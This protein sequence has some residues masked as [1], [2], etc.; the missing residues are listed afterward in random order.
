MNLFDRVYGKQAASEYVNIDSLMAP[1]VVEQP[2]VQ[3]AQGLAANGFDNVEDVPVFT[4]DRAK[5]GGMQSVMGITSGSDAAARAQADY[6]VQP[7]TFKNMVLP[8][9]ALAA[10]Q[11]AQGIGG[12]VRQIG[13]VVGSGGMASWGKDF[14]QSGAD[15]EKQIQAENPLDEGTWANS[16]RNAGASMY[17]QLPSMVAAGPLVKAG[18]KG[19]GMATA[20]VPMGAVTG[21]QSYGKYRDR[22][23]GVG[24]ASGGSAVDELIEVGTELLP[25]GRLLTYATSPAKLAVKQLA[26]TMIK[27]GAE[28]YFGETLAALGQGITN[29]YLTNPNLTEEQRAQMVNDYF[30]KVN[31]KTGNAEYFDDFKEA[32]RATTAQLVMTAGLGAGAKRLT[33]SRDSAVPT[34]PAGPAVAPG[35]D[36][37]AG[38]PPAAVAPGQSASVA[39][40]SFQNESYDDTED[41]PAPKG[42]LQT[43]TEQA[44]LAVAAANAGTDN[45]PA[46]TPPSPTP[47]TPE[48][49]PPASVAGGMAPSSPVA[50]VV[51]EPVREVTEADQVDFENAVQWALNLEKRGIAVIPEIEGETERDRAW[52]L[53]T[54]YRKA[55]TPMVAQ[56]GG[57]ENG[58]TNSVPEVQST[59]NVDGNGVP[60]PEVQAPVPGSDISQ[61]G[62]Q[63]NGSVQPVSQ[64]GSEG[65]SQVPDVRKEDVAYLLPQ[66]SKELRQVLIDAGYVKPSGDVSTAGIS[67]VKRL[68]KE[69][70]LRDW[71][72]TRDVAD[73]NALIDVVRRHVAPASPADFTPLD[74]NAHNAATSPHN[75]TPEPTL[76]QIE[77]GNYKKGHVTLHGLDISIENPAGSTRKGVDENGKAWET[78]LQHHYGYIKGTIGRDKDHVDVFIKPGIDQTTAGDKIFVIDQKSP[79]TDSGRGSFDEHKVMIGFDSHEEASKAYQSNYDKS[80][81]SRI[82]AVS[83]PSVATFK[84]WLKNGDTT[85]MF[86]GTPWAV[87]HE[88]RAPENKQVT[89]PDKQ[90]WEMT[91]KDFVSTH[92]EDFSPGMAARVHQER[93][94]NAIYDGIIPPESVVEKSYWLPTP[95]NVMGLL[96]KADE[97][98]PGVLKF[99]EPGGAYLGKKGL[100]VFHAKSDQATGLSITGREK[101]AELQ[102]TQEALPAPTN[103]EQEKKADNAAKFAQ[104]RL[105]ALEK[106]LADAKTPADKKKARASLDAHKAAMAPVVVPEAPAAFKGAVFSATPV[107][108]IAG[109]PTYKVHVNPSRLQTLKEIRQAV[110]DGYAGQR[111]GIYNTNEPGSTQLAWGSSFPDY[112]KNKGYKKEEVLRSIDRIIAGKA[113]TE[114]QLLALDDMAGEQ[115]RNAVNIILTTRAMSAQDFN[116]EESEAYESTMQDD[117]TGTPDDPF[118]TEEELKAYWEARNGTVTEEYRAVEQVDSGITKQGAEGSSSNESAGPDSGPGTKTEAGNDSGASPKVVDGFQLTAEK[119]APPAKPKE[120]QDTLFATP[121]QFGSKPTPDTKNDVT[122]SQLSDN[123]TSVESVQPSLADAPTEVSP[124]L[125]Q[126]TDIKALLGTLENRSDA[127]TIERLFSKDVYDMLKPYDSNLAYHL[128]KKSEDGIPAVLHINSGA[129]S[130][131]DVIYQAQA[132]ELMDALDRAIALI[133]KKDAENVRLEEANKPGKVVTPQER[134]DK[135]KGWDAQRVTPATSDEVVPELLG[136]KIGGARKDLETS[137]G[138]GKTKRVKSDVPAWR[139]R[140]MAMEGV[141]DGLWYL[142]DTTTDRKL[143]RRSFP[144]LKEAEEM[145]PLAVVAIKHRVRY[146]SDGTYKI[147]RDV[148]DH[149]RV[150]L[151][152]GFASE[153]EAKKYM[154]TH[155]VE[156]I[157]QDTYFGAEIL[158]RPEKVVRSGAERRSGNAKAQDFMDVFGFRSAEFGNWNN[159]AERQEILNHAYDGLLD[160]ADV[161]GLPTKALSLN[162]DLA[163]A[164]GARGQ[165]LQGAAAHYETDYA[166]INLTKLSGA[167]NLAHEW[168]H[169]VDN[170]FARQDGQISSE[171]VKNKRGDLVYGGNKGSKGMVTTGFLAKNSG[172]REAVRDAFLNLMETIWYKSEQYIE[173]TVKAEKFVGKALQD[174]TDKL[175]SLRNALAKERQYGAKKKAATPEQ[176][177]RFDELAARLVSGKD[178]VIEWRTGLGAKP[179]AGINDR[180]AWG[181]NRWTNDT[182]EAIAALNK[183]ITGRTGFIKEGHGDMNYLASHMRDFERRNKM[184]EEARNSDVKTKKIPTE[185]RQDAYKIDQGRTGDYWTLKEEMAARAFSAYIEDRIAEQGNRSDFLSYGSDNKFYRMFGI[186]P[187]PEGAERK[188]INQAFDDLFAT[189]ETKETDK[190]IAVFEKGEIYGTLD[191][192]EVSYEITSVHNEG[193]GSGRATSNGS[194]S[195]GL[196]RD[197]DSAG[198]IREQLGLFTPATAAASESPTVTP[199]APQFAGKVVRV[200]SGVLRSPLTKIKTIKD[201][202]RVAQP[203]ANRAQEGLIAIV[204]DKSGKILGVVQHTTG[205][206]NQ[207]IVHPR[208]LSGVILDFPGATAVYLAHNHPTG[209]PTPSPEDYAITKRV[210]RVLQAA[211]IEVKASVQVGFTGEYQSFSPLYGTDRETGSNDPAEERGKKLSI[212][213]RNIESIAMAEPRMTSALDFKDARERYFPGQTGILLIDGKNRSVGFIPMPVWQMLRLSTGSKE[214]GAGRIMHRMHETGAVGLMLS[215]DSV[216]NDLEAVRNVISFGNVLGVKVLD[217]TPLTG[218]SMQERGMLPS[219]GDVF[220]STQEFDAPKLVKSLNGNIK[221]SMDKLIQL[222]QA[223]IRDGAATYQQ[224]VAGMKKYL[225]DKWDTFRAAMILVYQQAKKIVAD[226]R[227]MVGIDI[228][229]SEAQQQYNTVAAKYKNSPEWMK[230][231]NGKPTNLNEQQWVQVRTPLFKVWFGDWEKA[232]NGKDG[233]GVWGTDIDVSKVVDENGEPAVVYHGTESGG[234]TVFR[235]DKADRHRSSMIFAA[236]RRDVAQTYSGLGQEVDLYTQEVAAW[237]NDEGGANEETPYYELTPAERRDADERYQDEVGDYDAQR[238]IYSVFLNIRN[239]NEASFEGANWDGTREGQYAVYDE[240]GEQQYTSDGTAFFDNESDAQN[241]AD[242]LGDG[243]TAEPAQ[244]LHET[245]NSIAEEAKKMGNDG[246]IIRDVIDDGG[247]AGY[248]LDPADVFVFF[249]ESQI[250]S[251]VSNTGEFSPGN[252]DIRYS[253]INAVASGVSAAD[254][255]AIV[256]KANAL[257][258]AQLS[259]EQSSKSLPDFVLADMKRRGVKYPEAVTYTK[260]GVSHIVYIADNI[261]GVKRMQA[262]MRHEWFHAGVVNKELDALHKYYSQKIPDRLAEIAAQ[263]KFDLK[264]AEGRR[265]AAGEL[266]AQEA[267]KGKINLFVRQMLAKVKAWLRSVGLASE[268]GDAEVANIIRQAIGR[269]TEQAGNGGYLLN[270]VGNYSLANG[271]SFD[272]MKQNNK[273]GD[274]IDTTNSQRILPGT[275]ETGLRESGKIGSLRDRLEEGGAT[276][277]VYSKAARER[278]DK[279]VREWASAHNLPIQPESAFLDVWNKTS[280]VKGGENRVYFQDNFAYKLNNLIYHDFSIHDFADRLTQSNSYF[281]DTAIDI[282]G[283]AK[284]PQGLRPLLQQKAVVTKQGTIAAKY[285]IRKEL[286]RIGFK[287]LDLDNGIWLSP[288]QGYF[289]SDAGTN[290]VLLDEHGILR[291]IDVIFHKV[292]QQRIDRFVPGLKIDNGNV[293]YSVRE[294]LDKISEA[295]TLENLKSFLDPATYERFAKNLPSG[296]DIKDGVASILSSDML[297]EAAKNHLMTPLW[298]SE[299]HPDFLPVYETAKERDENMMDYV[300]RMLGGLFDKDGNVTPWNKVRDALFNWESGKET[301]WGRLLREMALTGE[302]RTMYDMLVFEA[303]AMGAEYSSLGYA[304]RNPRIK[305][306]GVTERIFDFYQKSMALQEN[307]RKTHIAI[308]VELM[309]KAGASL[310]KIAATLARNHADTEDISEEG[311][312]GELTELMAQMEKEGAAIDTIARHVADYRGLVL[313]RKGRVHRNHGEGNRTVNVYH[314]I[315]ALD[316]EV[317]TVTRADGTH[318][319]IRLPGWNFPGNEVVREIKK[320]VSD[321]GGVFKQTDNGALVMLFKQGDGAKAERSFAAIKLLDDSGKAIHKNLVYRRFVGSKGA[322]RK[323]LRFVQSD[324]SAAMPVNYQAGQTYSS[325][326][327]FK[328]QVSEDMYRDAVGDMATEQILNASINKMVAHGEISK[329]EAA[330]MKEAY[331]RDIAETFMARGAGAYQIR[332]LNHLIEGYDRSD[333]LGK[334]ESYVQG[335]SGMLSKAQYSFDQHENMQHVD[336]ENKNYTYTYIKDSLRNKGAWD[337]ASG[338]ARAIASI[339]YLGYNFSWMLINSTQ[340]YVLGQSE[341]SRVTSGALRKIMSAEKDILT[342]KLSAEEKALFDEMSV[343]ASDHDSVMAEMAGSGDGGDGKWSRRLGKWVKTSMAVGQRVEVLNRHTMILAAY[344]VF[345]GEKGQTHAEALKNAL[346]INSMSNIDMGRHNL[347]KWARS[348]VG[349]T[350]YALQSYI[351]HMLNM[352]YFRSTSGNRADQKAVLRLLFAMFLI[353]GLP[354]GAPGSD[355]LD[356]LILKFFGYSPKLALKEWTRKMA[357]EFGTPGEMMD[358]FIWHGGPGVAGV[359]LTGATQMRLPAITNIIAG[360]DMLKAVGGPV[361]GLVMKGINASKAA[362]RGDYYRMAEYILPTV[363]ANPMSGYRQYSEGVRSASG[364]RVDYKG[365]MLKMDAGEALLRSVG[366]Q[367]ARIAD[368]SETR[369]FQKN[370]D[371]EWRARK[372][373]VMDGLRFGAMSR[374]DAIKF[375]KELRKSQAFPLVTII[376]SDAMTDALSNKG[377]FNKRKNA[378]QRTHGAE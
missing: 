318:D 147:V 373:E 347:P 249:D 214:S 119:A 281:P 223:V 122:T 204:V 21:G 96:N 129:K 242:E 192:S 375:N 261:S 247:K 190:G 292:T 68:A 334:F 7:D 234:F 270:P 360:D 233:N 103:P 269:V 338:N 236:S 371:F 3:A 218:A 121:P 127:A 10:A 362:Q 355:D 160:L 74:A 73:Y 239:P 90:P 66:K 346:R 195:T 213:D 245:T 64:K 61:S 343:K 191:S 115:R 141:A 165:G 158:A 348:A 104:V 100:V 229:T 47:V 185:Y 283:F 142:M 352:L 67:L 23:F 198:A 5:S 89:A 113:V 217:A 304:N 253:D 370:L 62:G 244:D 57:M 359:S 187:F 110:S 134:A 85:K 240:E 137:S 339:W 307:A 88:Y 6:I 219:G 285:D 148:T 300:I 120:K 364:V 152:D 99:S 174:V 215:I 37:V 153:D 76:A 336:P 188:A 149:K 124:R 58:V 46:F 79:D 353:G 140:Y 41:M 358:S 259:V 326:I 60:L 111:V 262:L 145:L 207:S 130:N 365:K 40:A 55:I 220:Y 39:P 361:G 368:I 38:T 230:A 286:E 342:G 297:N 27:M 301:A 15:V 231:P 193:T 232:H 56:Q 146:D 280:K 180:G 173:D 13:D 138:S 237:W 168:L 71:P 123:L 34:D 9:P 241:F 308:I 299:I 363:F 205:S 186:K 166:V 315:T 159:A 128:M 136:E 167:G 29:K 367:P 344:R 135:R 201:A 246:A 42:V 101:L 132:K 275:S 278:Q 331:I 268:F 197:V 321:L 206:A 12:K 200:V 314:H 267:E 294:Q 258:S 332:R 63:V 8:V 309:H 81:F 328:D 91:Q 319:R 169:A 194:S 24:A 151:K 284:T 302:E 131:K 83:G 1:D 376:D 156:L 317:D 273:G 17:Q 243:F 75:N 170:Y 235:P 222:G 277:T 116:I 139:R 175:Q 35:A 316:F 290:N 49:A 176:L 51:V 282:I 225:G 182:L 98:K 260:D 228:N 254:I 257:S 369:G 114:K 357:K 366:L 209:D 19:L 28:E 199:A 36:P 72:N 330:A 356:K 108:K 59:A 276:G 288:D 271:K 93:V 102:S 87:K 221:Q 78:G 181:Q 337:R 109:Y 377:S 70:K 155:A 164:F 118:A 163:I 25:A 157:E 94:Q 4:N 172:V 310:E 211:G 333:A 264:T 92:G 32:W 54:E 14:A 86:G 179:D 291:F 143:I 324:Y 208:D 374:M 2:V 107:G 255:T 289:L 26:S 323:H 30:T 44:P 266:A 311:L 69:N 20:L 272:I 65:P 112:F 293:H 372:K 351:Q 22:G 325:D 162:G 335:V 227:G 171:K 80:G 354:A 202:A 224:F 150:T 189:L 251:A 345:T 53:L 340:P 184:L 125:K 161:L 320:V 144:T 250:K 305:A 306:L 287:L 95:E 378:W 303:D 154:A 265:Q 33:Q 82:A 256:A 31:P 77:A 313:K 48:P 295:S 97:K 341:L 50:S 210:A 106:K 11:V 252:A 105:K 263:R 18:M 350:L 274:Y 327:G 349:R 279:L 45:I 238:G 329:E 133:K 196:A 248:G 178:A 226:E 216:Y 183:E 126:L 203:I 177:A 52:R 322:A 296:E 298:M 16:I 212:Y 312:K 117:I 84:D 43:A